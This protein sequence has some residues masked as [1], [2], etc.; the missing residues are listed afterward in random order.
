MIAPKMQLERCSSPEYFE[1]CSDFGCK[2]QTLASLAAMPSSLR[3]APFIP[4]PQKRLMKNT[5][6]VLLLALC[7][8]SQ[9][10]TTRAS[11]AG[12]DCGKATTVPEKLI[13][14]NPTLSELDGKMATAFEQARKRA[15]ARADA[16]QRDQ[17]IWLA[18]RN[19]SLSDSQFDISDVTKVYNERI[20]FLDGAF[21]D[22]A[23]PLL[24]AIMARAAVVPT[25]S[26]EWAALS[27]NG[28]VFGMA[29]EVDGTPEEA[30]K[31]MSADFDASPALTD[32]L[33]KID[34]DES[35]ITVVKLDL[36]RMGGI[37]TVGGTAH[38]V[39]WLTLFRWQGRSVEPLA[40]PETL[41]DN[42]WTSS[43]A[44]VNLQ[45]QV[46]AMQIATS[47][48]H[49]Y[50][51]AQPYTP[52]GWGKAER[53]ILSYDRTLPTPKSHCTLGNC[54]DLI[55][56]AR[57]A[58]QRYDHRGDKA[59]LIGPLSAEQNKRFEAMRTQAEEDQSL[60]ALPEF[61]ADVHILE[62][63]AYS[64]FA[65]GAVYFPLRHQGEVLLAR[66]GN[67]ALGWRVSEDWLLAAWRWDGHEFK[68]VLGMSAPVQ[69]GNF[70]FG[71]SVP[72]PDAK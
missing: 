27:G 23:S 59:A 10:T 62:N 19:G 63:D 58:I 60:N 4:I 71:A 3:L 45:N 31:R 52:N 6:S 40:V 68:P 53:L 36:A 39:S 41:D 54:G 66:I 17:L 37:Y 16:L 70:L 56:Q 11:A 7:L 69:R 13:C 44:L 43:G 24:A 46:Y 25:R 47:V 14:A 32:L 33:T 9:N 65:D 42:C 29:K 12:F 55:E 49:L 35:N 34:D 72:L 18:K 2:V 57:D 30:K 1:Q 15:G 26:D 8:A 22:P 5:C 51:Q 50:I 67:A 28:T 61:G 48:D 64:N 21:T 38:C 20:T